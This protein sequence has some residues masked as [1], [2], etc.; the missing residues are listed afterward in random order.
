MRRMPVAAADQV[1]ICIIEKLQH[2]FLQR[3][4]HD[5][6]VSPYRPSGIVQKPGRM[7]K[8]NMWLHLHKRVDIL[9]V[10]EQPLYFK[11]H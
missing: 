3:R 8:S 11:N 7:V 10:V 4:W 9:T 5:L 1:E 2:V 6:Y